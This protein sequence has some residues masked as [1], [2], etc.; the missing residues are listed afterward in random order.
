[1]SEI[2]GVVVV[3]V[4]NDGQVWA[5]GT[6]FDS[7]RSGYANLESAQTARARKVCIRDFIKNTCSPIVAEHLSSYD[8]E[9]LVY[10]IM[11]TAKWRMHITKIGYEDA[12]L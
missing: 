4:A 7:A 12:E 9:Q 3:L 10:D 2:K 6:D 11:N 5:E 8:A 1:M